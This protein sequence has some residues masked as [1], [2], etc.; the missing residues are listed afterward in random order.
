MRP[1]PLGA[2][3]IGAALL[4]AVLLAAGCSSG[5]GSGAS[6]AT[7]PPSTSAAPAATSPASATVCPKVQALRASLTEL[8]HLSVG[9]NALEKLKADLTKVRADLVALHD[10][11]GTEWSGQ[12]TALQNAL[13]KLGKTLSNLGSQPNATAAAKAVSTD[14]AAVTAAGSTLLAAAS[15]RCPEATPTPSG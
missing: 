15:V 7:S 10:T 6:P 2:A 3:P 8:A 9:P 11:A 13:S 12:I 4:S 14:L 5:G 1:G